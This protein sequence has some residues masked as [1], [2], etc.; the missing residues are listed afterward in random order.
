VSFFHEQDFSGGVIQ[1][2]LTDY[3]DNALIENLEFNVKNNIPAAAADHVGVKVRISYLPTL[4]QMIT[5]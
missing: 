2:V 4:T 1:V 3:P 5:D